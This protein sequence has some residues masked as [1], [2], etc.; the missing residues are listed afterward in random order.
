MDRQY[1]KRGTDLIHRGGSEEGEHH[2][3]NEEEHSKNHQLLRV[4]HLL[5]VVRPLQNLE[6][7]L[8]FRKYS[9]FLFNQMHLHFCDSNSI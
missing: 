8:E 7:N 5:L 6:V 9:I 3:T 4:F 1:Q 2:E